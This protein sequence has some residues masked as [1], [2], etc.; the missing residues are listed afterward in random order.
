MTARSTNQEDFQRF[1]VKLR[2]HIKRGVQRPYLVLD[3]HC[4][5]RTKNVKAAMAEHFNVLFLPVASS[6]FN[7]CEWLW[8]VLKQRFTRKAASASINV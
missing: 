1:L 2:Q 6:E 7:S 3:N 8:S 5:H 4:A